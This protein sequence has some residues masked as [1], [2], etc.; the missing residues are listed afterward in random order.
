VWQLASSILLDFFVFAIFWPATMIPRC[1]K[2]T[3]IKKHAKLQN[4]KFLRFSGNIGNQAKCGYKR[5]RLYPHFAMFP[6]ICQ[7][8]RPAGSG[9]ELTQKSG[10]FGSFQN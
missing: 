3:R 9:A 2:G 10:H 6:W 5:I 8:W 1:R 7:W 4:I